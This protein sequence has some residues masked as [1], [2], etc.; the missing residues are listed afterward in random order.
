RDLSAARRGGVA[1]AVAALAVVLVAWL[2]FALPPL[3][4]VLGLALSAPIAAVCARAFAQTGSAPYGPMGQLVQLVLGPLAGA[5]AADIVAASIV[6]GD[7]PQA[8]QTTAAL[9]VG[10]LV[11]TEPRAQLVGQV[12]GVAVGTAVSL[13]AYV[14]LV[15]AY[16][17]AS[18]TLPVPFGR[19]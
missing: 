19:S 11:G 14:L 2:A 16:G 18:P 6:A 12:V 4:A 17:L 5:P 8:V 15:R 3:L 1:L 7:S 10:R 9:K 13:P